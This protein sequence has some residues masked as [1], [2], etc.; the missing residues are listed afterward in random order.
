MKGMSFNTRKF[1][2]KPVNGIF[3]RFQCG[4][5]IR[6]PLKII[7][8]YIEWHTIDAIPKTIP[9]TAYRPTD[10][11]LYIYIYIYI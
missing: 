10:R 5:T 9:H 3:N 11:T 4:C 2:D 6:K 8:T 7:L 1:H